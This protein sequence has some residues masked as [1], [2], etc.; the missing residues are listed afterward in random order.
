[1][2]EPHLERLDT[3]W[4]QDGDSNAGADVQT[5]KVSLQ[6]AGGGL[7]FVVETERWACDAIE[8]LTGVLERVA[9]MQRAAGEQE[10]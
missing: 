9:A 6:D 7:F 10:P 2:S 4:S 5:L 3:F 1:M 8:D